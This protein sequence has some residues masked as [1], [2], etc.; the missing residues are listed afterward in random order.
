MEPVL[1]PDNAEELLALNVDLINVEE[2]LLKARSLKHVLSLGTLE[3]DTG[4]AYSC[5]PV[6]CRPTLQL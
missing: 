5:L 1:D 6:T 4:A 2:H 3:S